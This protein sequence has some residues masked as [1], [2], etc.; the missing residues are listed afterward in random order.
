M[1]Q[2]LRYLYM[3]LKSHAILEGKTPQFNREIK[4]P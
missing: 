4:K 2:F 3:K 1:R